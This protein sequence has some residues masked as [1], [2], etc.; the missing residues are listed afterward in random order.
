MIA[1]IGWEKWAIHAEFAPVVAIDP[2]ECEKAS[3]C[4]VEPHPLVHAS[5]PF[6]ST[7]KEGSYGTLLS[8]TETRF[9][10]PGPF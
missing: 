2:P 8:P 5:E 9:N 1:E 3:N 6:W 4:N 7:Q 10:G